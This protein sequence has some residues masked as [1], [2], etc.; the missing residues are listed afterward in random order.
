MSQSDDW[1]WQ[2]SNDRICDPSERPDEVLGLITARHSLGTDMV[3]KALTKRLSEVCCITRV[4]LAARIAVSLVQ[5][6]VATI[7]V[8]FIKRSDQGINFFRL[9]SWLSS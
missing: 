5:K 9:R 6:E 1:M 8:S 2:L 4:L 3:V 7:Y